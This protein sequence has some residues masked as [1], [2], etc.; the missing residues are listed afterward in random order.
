MITKEWVQSNLPNIVAALRE[1][2]DILETVHKTVGT[3]TGWPGWFDQWLRKI[4][5]LETTIRSLRSEISFREA[6]IRDLKDK[7]ASWEYAATRGYRPPVVCDGCKQYVCACG[8]K[9]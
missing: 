7:C 8:W 2:A 3:Q 6:E 5:E 1:G 9:K 4:D